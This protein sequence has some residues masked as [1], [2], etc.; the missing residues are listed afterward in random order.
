MWHADLVSQMQVDLPGVRP[1]VL[2]PDVATDLYELR[3]FRHFFRNAYVLGLD[4]ERVH[5]TAQRA[6][7]VHPMLIAGL[8]RLVHHVDAV[9]LEL[10]RSR[11]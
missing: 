8:A 2:P 4:P 1:A 9:L 10:A 3:R 6:L 11:A 7:R 5:A